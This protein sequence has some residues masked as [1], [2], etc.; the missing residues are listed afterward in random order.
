M[1]KRGDVSDNILTENV[2]YIVLFIVFFIGM[3]YY[4]VS[5]QDGATIWEDFYAKEI[6]RIIDGAEPGTEVFLDVSRGAQIA[7]RKGQLFSNMIIIDNVENKIKVSLRPNRGR[8]YRY[9][10]KVDIVQPRIE[11]VSGS[12]DTNRLYFR[13]VQEGAQWT[14]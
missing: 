12:D 6:A 7:Q 11:L 13:I 14:N 2:I 1:N 8:T 9:Y 4:V 5:F 3:F 10:N